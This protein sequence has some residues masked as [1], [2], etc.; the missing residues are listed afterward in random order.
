VCR[1]WAFVA[2]R[3]DTVAIQDVGS[4]VVERRIATGAQVEPGK[5]AAGAD[6]LGH[7]VLVSGGTTPRAGSLAVIGTATGAA[8]AIP[9]QSTCPAETTAPWPALGWVARAYLTTG[10]ELACNAR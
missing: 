2:S 5:V 7:L 4:G 1:A 10:H 9:A 3:G 6:D 8:R